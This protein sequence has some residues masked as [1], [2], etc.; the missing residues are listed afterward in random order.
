ATVQRNIQLKSFGPVIG[1]DEADLASTGWGIVFAAGSPRTAAIEAALGPLL[2]RR[3]QQA[4]EFY[5]VFKSEDGVK[6]GETVV[7]WLGRQGNG[8]ELNLVDPN[9]GVPY[10]LLIVGTPE[11]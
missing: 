9:D 3:R 6:V 5:K 10:Y 8:P 7:Q 2:E 11:D 1:V 4:G